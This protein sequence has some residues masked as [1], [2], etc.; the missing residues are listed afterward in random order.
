ML[1][2]SKEYVPTLSPY[3]GAWNRQNNTKLAGQLIS[4]WDG[5]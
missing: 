3:T 4:A 1:S 5:I 2:D